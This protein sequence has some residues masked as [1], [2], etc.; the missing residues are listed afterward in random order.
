[1]DG[2]R[3]APSVTRVFSMSRELNVF[4]HAYASTKGSTQPLI[5]FA[6]LYRGQTKAFETIPLHVTKSLN[7]KL[8]TVPVKFNI[9]LNGLLPGEYRCQVSILD[10]NGDKATFWQAQILLLP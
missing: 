8:N 3:L 6:A 7:D 9:P 5:A 4:L 10:P 1:Q 2:R